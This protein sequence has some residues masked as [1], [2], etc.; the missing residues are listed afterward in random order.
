MAKFN[1]EIATNKLDQDRGRLMTSLRTTTQIMLQ[2]MANTLGIKHSTACSIV[3][4][5]LRTGRRGNLA[6]RVILRTASMIGRGKERIYA[7]DIRWYRWKM[8]LLKASQVKKRRSWSSI[9]TS[10]WALDGILIT[11]KV[12]L[13]K[14]CTPDQRNAQCVI[15]VDARLYTAC[16]YEMRPDHCVFIGE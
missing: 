9:S 15:H 12:N 7:R 14:M 2:C 5:Y 13:K 8:I 1:V 3:A 11:I 16:F 4:N 6:K 10:T